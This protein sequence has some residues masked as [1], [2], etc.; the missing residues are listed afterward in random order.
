MFIPDPNVSISDP[1][2]TRSRILDLDPDPHQRILEFLTQKLSKRRSGIFLPDPGSVHTTLGGKNGSN[3]LILT[4]VHYGTL[5]LC[6][7][8]DLFAH[9]ENAAKKQKI[10]LLLM[11]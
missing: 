3:K 5:L 2:L 1:G 11:Q 8:L 6:L 10:Y 9:P 4:L 7:R